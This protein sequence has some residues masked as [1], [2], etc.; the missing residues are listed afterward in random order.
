MKSRKL[1]VVEIENGYPLRYPT[2]S[3]MLV[4]IAEFITYERDCC[5]FFEFE[6]RV[7]GMRFNVAETHRPQR[8]KGFH[9]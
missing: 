8:S 9:S 4:H 5:P 6:L 2:D 7:E 1:D 3:E